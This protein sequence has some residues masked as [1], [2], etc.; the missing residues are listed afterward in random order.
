MSSNLSPESAKI[1]PFP[2]KS[3]NSAPNSQMTANGL[4]TKKPPIQWGGS[5]YHQ[6]A[7]DEANRDRK[8]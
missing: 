4:S 8:P 5:W 2:L 1:I 6:S 7:V 3:R